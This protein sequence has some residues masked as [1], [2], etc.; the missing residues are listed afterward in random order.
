[1][2]T[3]ISTVIALVAALFSPR[4]VATSLPTLDDCNVVWDSPSKDV[5]DTMP[6]GNGDISAHVWV[7]NGDLLVLIE[8]TDAWDEND[9]NCKL[10]RV[11]VKFSPN[12]FAPGPPFCP[13]LRLQQGEIIIKAG[14]LDEEVSPRLWVD[15]NQPVI[16]IQSTSANPFSQQVALQTWRN[17]KS[18]LT[19][20]QVSDLF[21]NLRGPAPYPTL[22]FP[23]TAVQGQK[24]PVLW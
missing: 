18:V 22:L 15:A 19:K 8:K 24:N 21:R 3:P 9:I 10:A 14:K 20:T 5:H 4:M 23:D 6:L 1:M 2:K 17:Q 7:Q 13:E 16:R 12:P 11:R